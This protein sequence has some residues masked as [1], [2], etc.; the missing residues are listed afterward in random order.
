MVV[1]QG[2]QSIEINQLYPRLA[3]SR[4]C[5]CTP[6]P[7]SKSARSHD[8]SPCCGLT[9]CN[10][11]H[12]VNLVHAYTIL[13]ELARDKYPL[14]GTHIIARRYHVS[15]TVLRR[16]GQ[17]YV[18][19]HLTV[20]MSRKP[21]ELSRSK[22]QQ[23]SEPGFPIRPVSD[24]IER[25][26]QVHCV[27]KAV[28]S[29]VGQIHEMRMNVGVDHPD[30]SRRAIGDKI[31]DPCQPLSR[32]IYLSLVPREIPGKAAANELGKRAIVRRPLDLIT[33]V[34]QISLR[35]DLVDTECTRT[36]K[37]STQNRTD[38][39]FRASSS[40]RGGTIWQ[41]CRLGT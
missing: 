16:G 13:T 12:P 37:E 28:D 20:Q 18:V 1:V 3:S 2:S 21:F 6:F 14:L 9:S 24:N 5:G 39:R 26:D 11:Q 4:F 33:P 38:L 36:R 19:P 15:T 22:R 17:N 29:P 35:M 7:A 25:R 10:S 34:L 30:R 8:D 32:R 27:R 41:S 23:G 31:K 40:H